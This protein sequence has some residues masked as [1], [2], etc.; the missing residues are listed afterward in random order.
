MSR[1]RFATYQGPHVFR[2]SI[3][4]LILPANGLPT[5][6]QLPDLRVKVGVSVLD[7]EKTLEFVL[8]VIEHRRN[9]SIVGFVCGLGCFGIRSWCQGGRWPWT[10]R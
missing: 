3:I 5:L 10:C 6:D 2:E 8:R 1:A 4:S 9:D 7:K